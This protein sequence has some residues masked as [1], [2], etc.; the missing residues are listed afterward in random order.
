MQNAAQTIENLHEHSHAQNRFAVIPTAD[1]LCAS[2]KFSGQGVTIA[3]LDSGFY[4]HPD[5]AD[6]VIAFHDVNGEE[7]S[8]AAVRESKEHHWH[9]TQ[10]VVSCAGNGSLSDGIYRGLASSADLVLVKVSA[11]G[12]IRDESIEKGLRW[13]LEH[14][15]KYNI[16]VLNMSLGGDEDLSTN[17]ILVILSSKVTKNNSR[18][19]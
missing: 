1:K 13:V 16:R 5:F 11:G 3:F 15:K 6:R 8:L 2:R 7:P 4:P 12:R 10:T 14:R 9:G 19:A 18:R 17:E